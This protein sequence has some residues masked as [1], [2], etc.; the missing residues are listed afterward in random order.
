VLPLRN[1]KKERI[2]GAIFLARPRDRIPGSIK[3]TPAKGG[4][5]KKTITATYLTIPVLARR[6][7]NKIASRHAVKN[8]SRMEYVMASASL[9]AVCRLALPTSNAPAPDDR[10]TPLAD[11]RASV[12]PHLQ[13]TR[14]RFAQ[15]TGA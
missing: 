9:P 2:V 1:A 10:A 4:L 5:K 13:S 15:T 7:R 3:R 8:S 12:S 6:K 14:R 11:N